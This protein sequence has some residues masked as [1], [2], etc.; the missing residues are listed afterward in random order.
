MTNLGNTVLGRMLLKEKPSKGWSSPQAIEGFKRMFSTYH[1]QVS[2]PI[3]KEGTD[4]YQI[5][6]IFGTKQE[7]QP[8]LKKHFAEYERLGLIT[9]ANSISS[10]DEAID[11]IGHENRINPIKYLKEA[12]IDLT[13]LCNLKCRHCYRGGSHEG[14]YGLSVEQLKEALNPLF[15]A[16]VKQFTF[17]GGEPTLRAKD[18]I[19]LIDYINR[20]S[21]PKRIAVLSNGAFPKPH[22]LVQ[23]LAQRDHVFLQLSLDSYER[24]ATDHN[25]GVPGTFAKVKKVVQL[26]KKEGLPVTLQVHMLGNNRSEEAQANSEYFGNN[27]HSVS[28]TKGMLMF[29]NAV[30]NGHLPSYK[31]FITLGGLSPK[32][33]HNAGWCK[34]FTRPT[35]LII[36]AD[37]EVT[38]CNYTYALPEEFGNLN[39]SSMVDIINNIQG[40][41]AYEMF[42]DGSIESY[43]EELD[44]NIFG[45]RFST[46]CEPMAL[47]LAYGMIK[48]KLI[49]EGAKDPVAQANLEVA[50]KY[51]YAH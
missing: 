3:L 11:A 33:S 21:Y 38:N 46:S 19:T 7:I 1:A 45:R 6:G 8:D 14:E 27:V 51:K 16:G 25:R 42:K 10:L 18:L 41:R 47:T 12:T 13:G 49:R 36:R 44:K 29:G 34:G 24:E 2:N 43:Q 17:T 20:N 48:E 32:Y 23:E 50:R 37:G 30:E 4:L 22:E 28:E 35:R 26:S 31:H 40:T 9:T 39:S 5:K 15:T